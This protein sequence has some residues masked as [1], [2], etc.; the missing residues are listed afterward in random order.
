MAR[1]WTQVA[2][3][4]LVSGAWAI[5]LPQAP[6]SAS[7][8]PVKQSASTN[9]SEAEAELQTGITLT[10]GGH[11][12][13]A[14]PHFLTA[15]GRVSDEYAAEFNLALCYVGTGQVGEAIGVLGELRKNGY[16]NAGVENLLAQA[17]AKS[18][19]PN[20]AFE[21][22]HRAVGFTPKDEKLYLYVADAFLERQAQ[23]QSLRVVELGLQNVPD[24]ARLHYERGY[25]LSLLDELDL[26]RPEFDRATALAPDSEI[27]Y[28]A[29]AQ[30]D[31]LDGSI[32]R[33]IQAARMGVRK[34]HP[35][36]Q[37]LAL[38]GEALLREGASPGDSEFSEARNAL[39]KSITARPNYAGSQ[40]A[41]G[42]LLLLDEHLDQ[43]IE[44]LEIGRVLDPKNLSVYA[45]LGSAYRKR[46][47]PERAKEML[48]ILTKLNQE[49]VR[50]IRT[51]PG[52]Q[53]AIPG[54]SRSARTE[55]KP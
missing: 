20:A 9:Q 48:A 29:A 10:R 22:L 23:A 25:L 46:G 40:I 34:G 42:H 44:H 4:A 15:R 1:R 33:S 24:S 26:A 32:P 8:A 27:G 5:A 51:A 43:G 49:Q 38:L 54:A 18:A 50:Q 28:L 30:K 52:D 37:L 6:G 3:I 14:I 2:A 21:A 39:E 17:Y 7:R 36:Y 16:E 11:F 55:Q 53:K 31:F 47:Q 45:L 41:M 19:Q 13:E 35:D 12:A